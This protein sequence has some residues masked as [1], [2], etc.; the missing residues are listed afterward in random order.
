MAV[1]DFTAF[2]GNNGLVIDI[3]GVLQRA[4]YAF[5]FV[6]P[7]KRCSVNETLDFSIDVWEHNLEQC[8]DSNDILSEHPMQIKLYKKC[9]FTDNTLIKDICIHFIN[10]LKSFKY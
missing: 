8:K 9:G 2:G 7:S 6:D 10:K 5:P 4:V 3:D 1:G